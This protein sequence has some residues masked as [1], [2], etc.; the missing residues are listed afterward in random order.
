MGQ[1]TSKK[2]EIQIHRFR[3]M[4][5]SLSVCGSVEWDVSVRCVCFLVISPTYPS[6]SPFFLFSNILSAHQASIAGRGV[7][8]GNISK[9]CMKLESN[10][11]MDNIF[12]KIVSRHMISCTPSQTTKKSWEW[13]FPDLPAAEFAF[14]SFVAYCTIWA[15]CIINWTAGGRQG[16]GWFH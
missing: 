3:S 13:T 5:V 1:S 4:W 16:T 9:S 14:A 11:H 15:E 12:D 8:A 7:R 10:T 2:S 6:F